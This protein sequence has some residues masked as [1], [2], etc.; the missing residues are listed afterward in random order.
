MYVALDAV[1]TGAAFNRTARG[2][3][4][5][6]TPVTGAVLPSSTLPLARSVY[7]TTLGKS[8]ATATASREE[9]MTTG[10]APS[11]SSGT[12]DAVETPEAVDAVETREAVDAAG[13]AGTADAVSGN[14]APVRANTADEVAASAYA[15]R[16]L[17]G[18]GT[19]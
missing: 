15:A 3:P 19:E 5:R 9:P 2:M 7:E 14:T 18:M 6:V 1:T 4:L 12:V 10:A 16:I 11:P 13:A 8:W 17:R